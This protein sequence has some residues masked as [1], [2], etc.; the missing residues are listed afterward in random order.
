MICIPANSAAYANHRKQ[1]VPSS[2]DFAAREE[3]ILKLEEDYDTSLSQ[4]DE[5]NARLENCLSFLTGKPTTLSIANTQSA[6][7]ITTMHREAA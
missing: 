1:I 3:V 2:V 7:Q 4:L 5:L 6:P